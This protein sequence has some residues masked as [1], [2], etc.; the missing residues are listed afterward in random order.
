MFRIIKKIFIV[1]LTSRDNASIHTKCVLLIN[2]DFMI[3]PSLINL[4]PNKYSQ[5]IHYYS[6]SV[7][8]DVLEVVI[9]QIIYL[10]K[11][12]FQIKLQV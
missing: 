7:K 11:Y 3:Q 8:L 12:V 10:I 2:K 6:F 9:L 1:L 5:D 4:H